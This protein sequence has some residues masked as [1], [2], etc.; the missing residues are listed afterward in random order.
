MLHIHHADDVVPSKAYADACWRADPR[1]SPDSW[2]E[3][4][5]V[6]V[7]KLALDWRE[8]VTQPQEL[9]RGANLILTTPATHAAAAQAVAQYME[10][11]AA[12]VTVLVTPQPHT[13]PEQPAMF[14]VWA[15]PEDVD[16]AAALAALTQLEQHARSGA[17]LAYGIHH[18]AMAEAGT[19][20][21]LHRWLEIATAA[22]EA[23]WGR[24]KRPALRLLLAEFD[25]LNPALLTTANTQSLAGG[26]T[27]V[28][29]P[30]E[31]AARRGFAVIAVAPAMPSTVPP[32]P[33]A[34]AALAAVAQA[35]QALL[36]HLGGQWPSQQGRPLFSVLAALTEGAS[37]WPTPHHWQGWLRHVHPRLAA[38]WGTLSPSPE[39][40]S[41]INAYLDAFT[42]LLPLA[43][44]LALTTAQPHIHHILTHLRTHLPTT[45]QKTPDAA[46]AAA[47]L[48]SVPGITALAAHPLP[49]L[50]PTLH[51]P[52]HPDI[53]TILTI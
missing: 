17:I 21:P 39:L 35:E 18:P 30:L 20:W 9:T 32:Q 16:E 28:V 12:A 51:L 49:T 50:A 52:V 31:L 29:T 36:N 41:L 46:L 2:R 7:G 4:L 25:L 6:T 38:A 24:K 5:G 44:H 11:P 40:G 37:P 47:I 1:I 43:N 10:D 53:S 8:E 14:V 13:L 26:K 3:M 34:L 22:A 45:W 19:P 33:Q 27:E 23:A 48:T 15:A 42:P